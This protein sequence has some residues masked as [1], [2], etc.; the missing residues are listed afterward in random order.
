MIQEVYQYFE[1][2]DIETHLP[3][4]ENYQNVAIISNDI[5]QLK[6][7]WETLRK[8]HLRLCMPH[9]Q[10]HFSD[11]VLLLS[12]SKK[13]CYQYVFDENENIDEDNKSC[14]FMHQ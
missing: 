11:D 4:I 3:L 14:K 5:A 7:K 10:Q 12:C 13:F 6:N 9:I 1:Y 8:S 2:F